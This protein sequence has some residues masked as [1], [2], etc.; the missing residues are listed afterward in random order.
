MNRRR[1][2]QSLGAAILGTALV[3]KLPETL[4]PQ[5]PILPDVTSSGAITWSMLNK[6]F[7]DYRNR[8]SQPNIIMV[9]KWAISYLES[10]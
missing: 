9:P 6:A 1:F 5:R 8:S 7:N 3:L 2:F 4:I 10:L